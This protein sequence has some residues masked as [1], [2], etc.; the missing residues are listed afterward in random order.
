V[1]V[2]GRARGERDNEDDEHEAHARSIAGRCYAR[3][4]RVL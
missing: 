4:V 3:V 2:G 1:G